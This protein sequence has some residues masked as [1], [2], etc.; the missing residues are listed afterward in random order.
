[1]GRKARSSTVPV[2]VSPSASPLP[3]PLVRVG[4]R[5]PPKNILRTESMRVMVAQLR[6]LPLHSPGTV[7]QYFWFAA[8]RPLVSDFGSK[9]LLALT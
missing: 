8:A 9:R 5:A 7:S 3:S 1:M 2:V 4:E 6:K